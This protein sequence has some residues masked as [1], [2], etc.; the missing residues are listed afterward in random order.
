MSGDT[1]CWQGRRE[2]WNNPGHEGLF[3]AVYPNLHRIEN[4]KVAHWSNKTGEYQTV[5][6]K[7]NTKLATMWDDRFF[8][9]AD[10]SH[11]FKNM[12]VGHGVDYKLFDY[13]EVQLEPKEHVVEISLPGNTD[14]YFYQRRYV[15]RTRMTWIS[16]SWGVHWDVGSMGGHHVQ[17][18][19]CWSYVDCQDFVITKEP[20]AEERVVDW[21][22]EE[23][24][25]HLGGTIKEY[26]SVTQRCRDTLGPLGINGHQQG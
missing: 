18:G 11:T 7:Y 16:D 21:K 22:G 26:P 20:L 2:I 14:V 19:T 15:F 9:H 6:V 13:T 5:K 8:H 24:V 23:W 17:E 1:I 4:M 25:N 12:S 10:L 3:A